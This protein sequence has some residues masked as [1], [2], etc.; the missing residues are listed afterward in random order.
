[1]WGKDSEEQRG[2][3]G[4]DQRGDDLQYEAPRGCTWGPTLLWRGGARG[5]RRLQYHGCLSYNSGVGEEV[6]GEGECLWGST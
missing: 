6:Q 2:G 4:E 1:M 3:Q 5:R